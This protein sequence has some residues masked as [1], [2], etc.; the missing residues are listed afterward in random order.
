MGASS[1]YTLEFNRVN[2][3]KLH[4]RPS[5]AVK[6]LNFGDI[7]GGQCNPDI[8]R[9]DVMGTEKGYTRVRGKLLGTKTDKY[10]LTL[11]EA[12]PAVLELSYL[13]NG[14]TSANQAAA[15][16]LPA[17]F[18]SVSFKEVYYLGKFDVLNVVVKDATTLITRVPE[19][20]YTLDDGGGFFEVIQGGAIAAGD[21]LVVK[22]DCALANRVIYTPNAKR[23]T[24]GDCRILV[25]DQFGNNPLEEHD[26]FGQYFI[27]ERG[28]GDSSSVQEFKMELY[29]LRGYTINTRDITG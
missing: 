26:F 17:A 29:P 5:G 7:K 28:G 24:Q 21:N 22:F 25:N 23:I 4:I 20:D 9:I 16:N 11:L 14:S 18:S 8:Q 1:I 15:T 27:T 10:E 12:L 2:T 3:Y 13:A 6:Y 19:V